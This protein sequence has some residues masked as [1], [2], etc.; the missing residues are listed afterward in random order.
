MIG[1]TTDTDIAII[2][3]VEEMAKKKGCSMAQISMAWCLR[4][5]VNP[6]VGFS[7]TGRV[8]EAVDTVKLLNG[9]ILTDED[10]KDLDGLYIPKPPLPVLP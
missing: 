2:N 7:S 9:G 3:R 4:K 1:P 6:I 8:D 5:G 10:V